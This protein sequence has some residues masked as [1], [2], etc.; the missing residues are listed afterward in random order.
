MLHKATGM[1]VAAA[2]VATV[3]TV[4]ADSSSIGVGIISDR[5]PGNFGDPKTQNTNL[6][7]LA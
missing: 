1:L 6:M 2:L 4:A 3:S 5:E 7:E